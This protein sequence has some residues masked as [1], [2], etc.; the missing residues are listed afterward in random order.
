MV[1]RLIRYALKATASAVVF[2]ALTYIYHE[3][4]DRFVNDI[5]FYTN[6][7]EEEFVDREHSFHLRIERMVNGRG[8][9]E[10]YVESYSQKL[11]VFMREDGIMLGTARYNYKNFTVEERVELCESVTEVPRIKPKTKV[12]RA[13]PFKRT[14]KIIYDLFRSSA[15]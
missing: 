4:I 3:P 6:E 15:D 14:L 13:D 9:L 8:N 11:P 5:I 10:T 1:F 2:G 12:K 7:A